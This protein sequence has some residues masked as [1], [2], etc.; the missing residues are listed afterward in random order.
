MSFISRCGRPDSSRPATIDLHVSGS[1]EICREASALRERM[2]TADLITLYV[3]TLVT[4][5]GG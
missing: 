3:E 4:S 2:R 5:G 1:G